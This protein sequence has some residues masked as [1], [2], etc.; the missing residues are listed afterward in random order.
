MV[1]RA[2]LFRSSVHA[3]ADRMHVATAHRRLVAGCRMVAIG[4]AC[5]FRM[6]AAYRRLCR[7][8]IF[9]GLRLGSSN[10]DQR[11][12]P[13]TD[14]GYSFG[15]EPPDAKRSLSHVRHRRHLRQQSS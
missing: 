10:S 9:C 12:W 4:L 8:G 14:G 7:G 13:P 3:Q 11:E 15:L 6:A 1:H 2:V 5:T